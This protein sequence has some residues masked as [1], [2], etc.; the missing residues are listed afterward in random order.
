MR[1]RLIEQLSQLTKQSPR[2]ILAS[3]I[4]DILF[5]D[6]HQLLVDKKTRKKH[7]KRRKH[8]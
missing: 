2:E 1:K 7:K 3:I 5:E 6:M 8:A 4:R